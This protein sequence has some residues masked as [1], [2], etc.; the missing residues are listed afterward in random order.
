LRSPL[1]RALLVLLAVLLLTGSAS[2][3]RRIVPSV[4]HIPLGDW[5]YDAMISLAADGLVPGCSARV[6]EGDRLFD[7]MQ[8]AEA[9]VSV[10]ESSKSELLISSQTALIDHLIQEFRPELGFLNEGIIDDWEHRADKTAV[11]DGETF[12]LGYV[13]PTPTDDSASSG[14]VTIPF[15]ISGFSSFSQRAFGIATIADR[16]DKFFETARYSTQPDKVILRGYDSNFIW[17]VGRE[18]QNW[19]PAYS[20]SLILSDNSASFWQA[21]G[22]KEIDLGRLIGRFKITE[23]LSVFE[24]KGRMLYLFGRRYERPLSERWFLGVSEAAKMN[25]TPNPAILVLPVYLY[26]HVLGGP[27]SSIDESLNALYAADLTYRTENGIEYYGEFL[28]DDIT[29]PDIFGPHFERPRKIGY[30]LGF[31]LPKLFAGERL[32]TFRAEYIFT[33]PQTYEATRAEF[34]ELAY[35]H[36]HAIIGHPIGPNAKALFLHGEYYLS[37]KWS[38]IGEYFHV[39]Q[40]RLGEPER[41]KEDI[42]SL[43]A[44]YDIAPDKS[45]ALR[46]APFKITCPGEPETNGVNYELRASFAF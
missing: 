44:A 26:Q 20:G 37:D 25:K 5:T 41:P 40:N 10:I 30:T 19:G 12:L 18:Y 22:I 4:D 7:R 38:L 15:R 24:D 11:S 27:G 33:D 1:R 16:E 31:F 8:M 28:I 21:R 35:T 36:D 45:I 2:A 17:S 29:A 6:F 9:L 14:N 43:M 42:I 23:S 3:G 39:R 46:V 34:P 32:S 13:R